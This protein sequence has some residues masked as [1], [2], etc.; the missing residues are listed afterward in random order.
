MSGE[1]AGNAVTPPG[2][3]PALFP[4]GRP[5]MTIPL[6]FDKVRVHT[7]GT[8]NSKSTVLHSTKR[9]FA[10]LK[11]EKMKHK[12]TFLLVLLVASV[13]CVARADDVVYNVSSLV[14]CDNPDCFP[15]GI[16]AS[17][18][19]PEH[20]RAGPLMFFGNPLSGP[21]TFGNQINQT[22]WTFLS[23]NHNV[24]VNTGD[25]EF[26]DID[27][28]RITFYIGIG[29][30]PSAYYSTTCYEEVCSPAVLHTDGPP[31]LTP[32]PSSLLLMGT[33]LLGV[34]FR[35]RRLWR[36]VGAS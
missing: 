29:G 16:S 30:E 7:R 8:S 32:E 23:D 6:A 20:E 15:I 35:R 26:G 18:E 34:A 13:A 4:F 10:A 24:Y 17:Y 5:F 22:A 14:T 33:G 31:I 2:A 27:D 9:Y 11:E 28:Y 25:L 36:S 3:G 19:L 12:L 21:M 1:C